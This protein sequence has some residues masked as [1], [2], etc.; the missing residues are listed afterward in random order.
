ME[1][2]DKYK[3]EVTAAKS[4]YPDVPNASDDGGVKLEIE[5]D[6]NFLNTT[7]T[8]MLDLGSKALKGTLDLSSLILPPSMLSE[9]TRLETIAFEYP[10]LCKYLHEAAKQTDP[11]ERIKFIVAGNVG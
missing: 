4:E 11:V 3:V 6:A 9:Y 10:T 7:K 5:S 2:Q 1:S 8:L